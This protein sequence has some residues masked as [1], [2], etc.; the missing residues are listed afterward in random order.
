MFDEFFYSCYLNK[1]LK[2][3]DFPISK[4]T[5]NRGIVMST[6]DADWKKKT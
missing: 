3:Y 1:L 2:V 5:L 4:I 6:V